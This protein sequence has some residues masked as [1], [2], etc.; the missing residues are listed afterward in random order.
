MWVSRI[1]NC[2]LGETS[3]PV[4]TAEEK[5]RI[6]KRNRDHGLSKANIKAELVDSM[7]PVLRSAT[8]SSENLEKELRRLT[9][10]TETEEHP[11]A[12]H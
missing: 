7:Q 10:L 3:P 8:I 1:W 2:C 11:S 12:F 4:G 6:T 9:E 5:D